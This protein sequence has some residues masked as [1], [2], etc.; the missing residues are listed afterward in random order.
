M[1]HASS[2]V[3]PGLR[4]TSDRSFAKRPSSVRIWAVPMTT[5]RLLRSR[6]KRKFQVR[7]GSSG[8]VSDGPADCNL[9][10]IA[11]AGNFYEKQ[12]PV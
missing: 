5:T 8:G 7:F 12:S 1:A 2:V 3:K 11:L 6:M 10:S 4:S 9:A